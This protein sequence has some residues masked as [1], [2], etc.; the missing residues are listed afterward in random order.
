MDLRQLSRLAMRAASAW[1]ADYASSM[2]AAL[3]YYALFSIAPLLLIVIGVAGFFFGAQAARGE[4]FQQ[5][6][7]MIG[8]D[9]AHAVEGL[10]ANARRPESGVLAMVTGTARSEERRVG[11]EC[12]SG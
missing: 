3:A 8:P 10:V 2:G 11:K 5:I 1:S 9:A 4:L 12:G 7:G 6:T